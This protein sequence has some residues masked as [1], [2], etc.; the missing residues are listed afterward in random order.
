MIA[1]I[2]GDILLYRSAGSCEPTKAKPWVE[3]AEIAIARMQFSIKTMLEALQVDQYKIFVGEGKTFRNHL[4]SEYKAHRV[5]PK[6]T[7]Y[8][9]LKDMLL[10]EYPTTLVTQIETDDRLGIEQTNF[11]LASTICSIDKDLLQIP[12]YHYNFV[13]LDRTLVSPLD[14]IRTFYR[15]LVTG[16]ATDNIPGYDGKLRSTIPQFLQVIV[17]PINRMDNEWDMYNYVLELYNSQLIMDRNAQ[18][19]Y[20]HKKE[21]DEWQPPENP[22]MMSGPTH[23]IMLSSSVSSDREQ[24]DIPPNMNV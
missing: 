12:G 1:L 17:D 9:L 22:D 16:D 5:K 24:G 3:P 19:L 8:A 4:Y 7:H 6:P 20:I 18:L 23:D 15:Q 13:K 10:K 2:D 14:G 11:G 21:N